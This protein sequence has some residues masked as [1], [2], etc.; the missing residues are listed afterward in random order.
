[1]ND[2]N[3]FWTCGPEKYH[4]LVED[5]YDNIKMVHPDSVT[6]RGMCVCLD[7][8]SYCKYATTNVIYFD[9]KGVDAKYQ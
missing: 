8:S 6:S 4:D 2:D 7:F 5:Y 9:G 1:M 3:N